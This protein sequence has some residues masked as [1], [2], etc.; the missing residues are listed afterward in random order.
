MHQLKLQ[1]FQMKEAI[2]RSDVPAIGKLMHESWLNK[3][4][5]ASGIS[6]TNIDKI[7]DTALAAGATGGKISGA[8]GGGFMMFFAEKND[9]YNVIEALK[10]LGGN[11]VTY[12]FTQ[13]GLDAWT[14]R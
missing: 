5:M 10:K 7:Y 8:G 9:R 12:E 14:I 1:A 11:T 2:L 6:N 3:K 13:K 4:E